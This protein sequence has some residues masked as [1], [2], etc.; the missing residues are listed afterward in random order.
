[1]LSSLLGGLRL[2]GWQGC[3]DE[4]CFAVGTL[5]GIHQCEAVADGAALDVMQN[6]DS[7]V[8]AVGS[9]RRNLVPAF[10]AFDKAHC[11]FPF[12]L[13]YCKGTLFFAFGIKKTG[14]SLVER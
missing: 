9:F 7:A 5:L 1:M 8:G 14:K 2:F 13:F 6:G 3:D 10:G 4:T 11:F 12:I